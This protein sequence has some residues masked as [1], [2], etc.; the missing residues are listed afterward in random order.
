MGTVRQYWRSQEARAYAQ[1]QRPYPCE[2]P[3]CGYSAG[4][5]GNLKK[6]MRTHTGKRANPCEFS[7]CEYSAEVD[8]TRE[9]FRCL[10]ALGSCEFFYQIEKFWPGLNHGIYFNL[11]SAIFFFITSETK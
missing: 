5:S 6:H 3:G 9:T 11:P 2:V 1:G 4:E 7:G 8:A 10:I